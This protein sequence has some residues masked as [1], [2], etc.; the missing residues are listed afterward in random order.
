VRTRVLGQTGFTVSELALGTW[1]LSGEAY[2]PVDALER[3][4]VI[5]RAIELGITLFET[6]DVYGQGEMEQILGARLSGK[7]TVVVTRVGTFRELAEDY[8]GVHKRFDAPYLRAAVERSRERLRRDKLD[9]VLLHNPSASTV[10][11]GEAVG[12]LKELKASGAIASWGVSAGDNVVARAALGHGAEVVEVPYNI[13]FSRELHELGSDITRTH[14]G[15]LARSILAYGILAGQYPQVHAFSYEDHRS[16]RWT[17]TEF[18]TR[19]RQL[20]AVRPLVSGDVMSMRA[21]AVRFVLANQMVTSAVLGPKDVPQLEQ[22]V[23]DA[24]TEPPYLSPEA[25][26]RLAADL[27]HHEVFT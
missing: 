17:R 21:A 4:R 25:L 8:A 9:L 2:G 19:V 10:S 11:R 7:S 6:A 20:A 1:G 22:L 12:V 24:G 23:R 26:T 13:F 5:D 16:S 18:E 15:V 27:A 3:D 14:A